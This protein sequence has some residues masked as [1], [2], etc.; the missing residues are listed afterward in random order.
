MTWPCAVRHRSTV[1]IPR[2]ALLAVACI[3]GAAHAH[4]GT[5]GGFAAGLHHPVLGLDHLL[6]M[7]SVGVISAQ[8]GGAAIW[9]IPTAFVAMMGVGGMLGLWRGDLVAIEAGIAASLVGLGLAMAADRRIPVAIAMAFVGTFAVFH[10]VAHGREVPGEVRSWAYFAGF[11]AGTAALHVAGVLI[12]FVA[13][14]IPH[15]RVAL[16][17]AGLAVAGIGLRLLAA[18]R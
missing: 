7:V 8:L 3:P 5:A 18:L 11:M 2:P 16:R 6:A 12:G 17:G 4:V 14:G 9:R 13:D 1:R 15:G 10:G